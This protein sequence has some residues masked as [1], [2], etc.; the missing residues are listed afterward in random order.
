MSTLKKKE[1]RRAIGL[2]KQM[3]ERNADSCET[4]EGILNRGYVR[5]LRRLV[6]LGEQYIA[7]DR[8]TFQRRA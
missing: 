5:A 6:V 8:A 2:V 7:K 3:L 4:F 1:V